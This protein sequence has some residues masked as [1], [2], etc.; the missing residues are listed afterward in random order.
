MVCQS[1]RPAVPCSK[2]IS[3]FFSNYARARAPNA[4]MQTVIMYNFDSGEGFRMK[5][6]YRNSGGKSEQTNKKAVAFGC[7]DPLAYTDCV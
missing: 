4:I 1:P 2:K 3:L 6:L 5:L 7:V